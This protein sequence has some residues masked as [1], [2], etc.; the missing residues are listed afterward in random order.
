MKVTTAVEAAKVVV[1]P[2][3]LKTVGPGYEVSRMEYCNA[4]ETIV[5][6]TGNLISSHDQGD[7]PSIAYQ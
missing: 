7:A 2:Y 5:E 4:V 1:I 3:E 6:V